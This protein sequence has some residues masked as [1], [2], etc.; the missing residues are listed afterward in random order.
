VFTRS[1]LH[2]LPDFWK[3]ARGTGLLWP[4]AGIA[5]LWFI[6]RQ[7]TGL[8]LHVHAMWMATVFTMGTATITLRTEV[9]PRWIAML[10]FAVALVL[11]PAWA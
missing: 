2:H 3:G 5:F 11:L 6:G 7:V 1:A 10:G 9:V 4:F 8:L